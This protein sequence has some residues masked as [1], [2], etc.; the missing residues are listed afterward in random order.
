MVSIELRAIEKEFEN[1]IPEFTKFFE[2]L[3]LDKE[4]FVLKCRSTEIVVC[5]EW[6]NLR[7]DFDIKVRSRSEE[8][9]LYQL[10]KKSL[11]KTNPGLVIYEDVGLY[12]KKE[13]YCEVLLTYLSIGNW[14]KTEFESGFKLNHVGVEI[15]EPSNLYRLLFASFSRDD[16]FNGWGFYETIKL[17]GCEQNEIDR[18]LQQVLFLLAKYNRPEDGVVGDYPQ[19]IP[20]T[21]T[22]NLYIWNNPNE[23]IE[24]DL[25]DFNT[26][27]YHEPIAFYNKGRKSE[28]PIYFYRVLEFFFIINRKNEIEE[29][30]FDYNTSTDMD[31]FIKNMTNL[32]G[33]KEEKDLEGLLRNVDGIHEVVE[34]ANEM[35]LVI[36]NDVSTFVKAL[37]QYRNSFVHAKWDYRHD[38]NIPN[39]LEDNV[40]DAHWLTILKKL[41]EMVIK[42]F[43]Y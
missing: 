15:S 2:I 4:R 43:C 30:I 12:S 26:T 38:I 34:K 24:I 5:I 32:Y 6:E 42:Q 1:D 14:P 18:V 31:G 28:E 27:K 36:S 20:Y 3:R 35:E 39:L 40:K 25:T 29:L 11:E 33:N 41:A 8:N 23:D 10:D 22:D 13:K 19:I 16:Y 9:L 21:Y 7:G 17:K 37:Y